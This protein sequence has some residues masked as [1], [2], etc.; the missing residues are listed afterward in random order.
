M[1]RGEREKVSKCKNEKWIRMERGKRG[2]GKSERRQ[3]RGRECEG[4]I[5]EGRGGEETK[6]EKLWKGNREKV[7][8]GK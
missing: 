6:W 4:E 1:E 3:A 7:K 2:K 8:N 5:L